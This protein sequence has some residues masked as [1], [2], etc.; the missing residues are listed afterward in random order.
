ME[1]SLFPLKSESNE[2]DGASAPWTPSPIRKALPP[3]NKEKADVILRSS[4]QVDF[5]V[6]KC[7]LEE[8]SPVFADM[9]SLAKASCPPSPNLKAEPETDPFGGGSRYAPPPDTPLIEL[10]EHSS[11]LDTL[12]RMFWPAADY[13]ISLG[14]LKPI[15][16]AAHK[17]QMDSVLLIFKNRLTSFVRTSPIRVYAISA[18]Y[19]MPDVMRAAARGFLSLS[20]ADASETYVDELRDISGRDYYRLLA[21]RRRCIAALKEMLVDLCW[22]PD[23]TWS[24]TRCTPCGRNGTTYPIGKPA[25]SRKLTAWMTAHYR[26]VTAL[27]LDRPC[28]E[29]IEEPGVCEEALKEATACDQ[30]RAVVHTQLRTF[31]STLR[32]TMD[33]KIAEVSFESDG[34]SLSLSEHTL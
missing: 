7:I 20:N 33:K 12:L 6:Y 34:L 23:S 8:V 26:R 18:Q 24:F 3:F 15:L 5:Y 1:G 17:Y 9:F 11:V 31:M 13:T 14:T 4:D 16:A 27:L 19:D 2:P 28:G 29:A 25:V 22:L 32:R 10:L 30:C 21:Y